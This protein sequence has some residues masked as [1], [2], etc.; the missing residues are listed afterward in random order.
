MGSVALG[1]VPFGFV[2]LAGCGL[3]GFDDAGVRLDDGSERSL[4]EDA[5]RAE[6]RSIRTTSEWR[7]LER[8]GLRLQQGGVIV[9]SGVGAEGAATLAIAVELGGGAPREVAVFNDSGAVEFWAIERNGPRLTAQ[10]TGVAASAAVALEGGAEERVLYFDEGGAHALRASD[11]NVDDLAPVRGVVGAVR[12]DVNG[13]DA[14]DTVVVGP[15]GTR[16]LASGTFSEQVIDPAA[17]THVVRTRAGYAVGY[18]DGRIATYAGQDEVSV[19]MLGPVRAMAFDGSRLVFARE[20]EVRAIEV[21]ESLELGRA[22]TLTAVSNVGALACADLDGDGAPE[23]YVGRGMGRPDLRIDGVT[24]ETIP[25]HLAGPS[26]AGLVTIRVADGDVVFAATRE[27]HQPRLFASS[28]GDDCL[29]LPGP[30]YPE[31]RSL[32]FGALNRFT[33]R[34]YPRDLDGDGDLDVALCNHR[35]NTD[36]ALLRNDGR[37]NFEAERAFQQGDVSRD[38][39]AM[40]WFDLQGDGR[41]DVYVSNTVFETDPRNEL[42]IAQPDGSYR[43]VDDP[44]GLGAIDTWGAAGGDFDGD[45]DTDLLVAGAA[46]SGFV[47]LLRNVEG[48]LAAERIDI[49]AATGRRFELRSGDMDGDGDPDAVLIGTQRTVIVRNDDGVLTEGLVEPV[50]GGFEGLVFDADADGDLDIAVGTS[51]GGSGRANTLFE[52]R[53]ASFQS[54]LAFNDV[55]LMDTLAMATF[56]VDLDGRAD[57]LTSGFGQVSPALRENALFLRQ[58]DGSYVGAPFANGPVLRSSHDFQFEDFDGDGRRE[59]YVANYGTADEIF[60]PDE[61]PGEGEVRWVVGAAP[62]RTLRLEGSAAG[63]DVELR[64]VAGV[65]L[66]RIQDATSVELADAPGLVEVRVRLRRAAGGVSPRL[67]SMTIE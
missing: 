59:L 52:R 63:I 40:V 27:R 42:Y 9:R 14:I 32:E 60:A 53:G 39:A 3:V 37:G 18:E 30:R 13:D 47:N 49:A 5:P 1:L 65:L 12:I 45:G 46:D 26:I 20:G 62:W 54:S 10:A 33:R 23:T 57:V 50:A 8:D 17:A 16:S 64:D 58:R 48:T 41:A 22:E 7:L 55:G 61:A 56:D 43:V 6:A 38:C 35:N 44:G 34:A 11:G 67:C 29:V 25:P 51:D 31:A 2:T 15:D 4:D 66:Q 21:G 28:D 19:E 36:N 24:Q